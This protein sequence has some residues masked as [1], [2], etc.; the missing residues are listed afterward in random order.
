MNKRMNLLVRRYRVLRPLAAL[1]VAWLS[2]SAV[3]A[4]ADASKPGHAAIASASPYATQAGMEILRAGGNAFDAAIAVSAALAV[5]EPT[6]S[7]LTGGG[8]YLLHR[9]SDGFEVA[10]DARERAPGAASRD[11]FLDAQGNP[12]PKLSTDSALAAGIP[13]EPAGLAWLAAHYGKLPA[14]RSLQPAIRLATQGFPL[15]RKVREVLL[16]KQAQ[17][18]ADPQVARNFLRKGQVPA[19]GTLIKQPELA[20]TLQALAR[21][22]I[23]S[24]YRGDLAAKLVSGVRAQGGIWTTQDLADYSAVER[25]P[26][27]AN[28]HGARIVSAPPPSSGGIALLEALNILSQFDLQQADP[29]TRKHL[30]VE[31]MRRA[32]RDRAVYLGDPDFVQMP[33]GRLLS[34]DYAAGLAASIRTDRA[35]ASSELPGLGAGA[36]QGP[37]TTHFSII[38]AEGNRVAATITLNFLFGSGRMIEGTG[39]FL[40]NEMDD[41]SIKPGVPN[42]YGLVGAEANAIAPGKR[43]L[44]SVTPSFVDTDTRSLVVGSPGGSFI[45]GMVL[46]ATLDFV[47]NKGSAHDIV[48]APR[49]HHQYL[50]DVLRYEP[51]AFSAAEL[52]GLKTRGQNLE[53]SDRQWGNMQ[54]VI[55]DRSSGKMEAASDPRGDGA[56]MT[57]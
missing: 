22:G 16:S 51:G 15:G 44:S 8:I 21:D 6:G 2:I 25:A 57:E 35:T 33:I 20:R 28:Y 11:M 31:A 56:G 18:A 52:D 36:P 55:W 38:D 34:N 9:S 32:H 3:Q 43:P 29:I 39:L 41:F 19:V 49:F 14:A 30:I 54:A 27:V 17:F 47:D 12:V 46:L 48:A 50:P 5:A 42:G 4:A 26:I 1:C 10:I 24:F 40:N 45:I 53:L 7:G 23:D 37:Q 13:G